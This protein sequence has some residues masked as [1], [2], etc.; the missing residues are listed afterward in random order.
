MSTDNDELPKPVA[1]GETPWPARP[2]TR[3]RSALGA[4]LAIFFTITGIGAAFQA[5]CVVTTI[6]TENLFA[7]VF[8]GFLATLAACVGLM[9][10][11]WSEPPDLPPD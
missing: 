7:G 9:R 6:A 11:F 10:L 3:A 4:A 1:R 8:L 5:T 2:A